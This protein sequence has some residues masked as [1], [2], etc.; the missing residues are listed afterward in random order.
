M[1]IRL[2]T[3][4]SLVVSLF[5]SAT[6]TP[7]VTRRTFVVAQSSDSSSSVPKRT[8]V[9]FE[10]DEDDVDYE[11][12]EAG[13]FAG[14]FDEGYPE[15]DE[16]ELDLRCAEYEFPLESFN[17]QND[18]DKVY[19]RVDEVGEGPFKL[20]DLTKLATVFG[21]RILAHKSIED[22][23]VIHMANLVA[24]LMD[25][26]GDGKVDSVAMQEQ[27]LERYAA[28][29]IVS[30]QSFT[31]YLLSPE[32]DEGFPLELKYCP[33]SFDYEE[34]S[35]IRPGGPVEANC[36]QDLFM[37]DRSVA[38]ASDHL[39]GR[40]WPKLLVADDDEMETS[41]VFQSFVKLYQVAVA[42]GT[43][44][45]DK[46]GC[47]EEDEEYC[48]MVMFASWAVTTYLGVDRC[49]CESVAAWNLCD[50]EATKAKYPDLVDFIQK[51]LVKRKP[52]G[53]YSPTDS[54]VIVRGAAG[55]TPSSP[56]K[57]MTQSARD[58]DD[59]NQV[60]E[61]VEEERDSDS[62]GED[63]VDDDDVDEDGDKVRDVGEEL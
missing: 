26:D 62:D 44:D 25:N 23:K 50:S 31:N 28:M 56:V 60:D 40:G 49:W 33:Y 46:T 55:E 51:Y 27:L 21:V 18:I 38:F 34:T 30:D 15:G 14:E 22:D 19:L 48:G 5:S 45:L 43:F 63:D 57:P 39:I 12:G 1:R 36:P 35:K 11:G 29:F 9:P 2:F 17:V 20:H 24:Q 32:E 10:A 61:E 8:V 6:L 59:A 54:S 4:L 13:A 47:P 52:D 41:A 42:D 58:D 53:K 16:G 37:K 7:L 3:P